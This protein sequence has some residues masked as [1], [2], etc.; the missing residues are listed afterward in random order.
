MLVTLTAC[1]GLIARQQQPS[2]PLFVASQTL[3]ACVYL[4]ATYLVVAKAHKVSFEWLL[5][6][7]VICRL[8]LLPSQPLF[9]NDIYRYLWDGKVL[10]NGVNPFL[11]PPSSPELAPLRDGHWPLIGYPDVRTIYPPLAQVVFGLSSTLGLRTPLGLK[12]LIFLFDVANILLIAGLLRRLGQPESWAIVYAWSPLA[13]KEFANSGH[14]EPVM[15]FL[16]LLALWFW[17]GGR[18]EPVLGGICF[19]AAVLVKL[20]PILLLPAAWR[21]GRW[22]SVAAATLVIA[23]V[24]LPFA[25]AGPMLF[26]GAAVYSK[27]WTFNYSSFGLLSLVFHNPGLAR[28]AAMLLVAG[29]SIWATRRLTLNDPIGVVR[30]VRN[31]LAV[32]LLLS[33][34]VD[35]WYVCWL[36]PFLCIAPSTG[37][38]L[39]TVTCNLSYLYYAHNTYPVWIPMLEYAPV[40]VLLLA[41]PGTLMLGKAHRAEVRYD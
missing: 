18:S 24:Y 35:P 1:L 22:K 6:V 19:G 26:Q 5:V 10:A 32:C 37:L 2:P 23:A 27:C 41:R 25:S 33:P 8:I 28:A 29:Y 4:F 15:I 17:L 34:T 30:I 21:L 12:S 3:S 14:I 38:L 13:I 20:I 9:D 31:V 40:Y 39:F 7:A 11:Y 36:L 16:V